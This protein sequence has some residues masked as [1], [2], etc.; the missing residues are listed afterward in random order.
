M[1]FSDSNGNLR[2][3]RYTTGTD[4]FMYFTYLHICKVYEL[5]NTDLQVLH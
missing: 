2:D 1:T 3:S 4:L 5:Y